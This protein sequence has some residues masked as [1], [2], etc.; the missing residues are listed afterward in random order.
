MSCP[1]CDGDLIKTSENLN[2]LGYKASD[3]THQCVEC[4]KSIALGKPIGE[5]DHPIVEETTCDVC[6]ETGY[7]YQLQDG[8][9]K[10]VN[11]R[12]KCPNCYYV[13]MTERDFKDGGITIGFRE[14]MGDETE[15]AWGY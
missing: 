11:L 12:F 7:L 5:F 15:Q 3:E 4:N 14:V 10:D 9:S 13:W 6:G 2:T 1:E 8:A